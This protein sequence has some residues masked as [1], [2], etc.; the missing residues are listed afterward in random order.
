MLLRITSAAVTICLLS[1]PLLAQRIRESEVP[2]AVKNALVGRYPA[3]A[4]VS[5][6]K[7]KGNF[8]ANWGGQSK[9]DN[10]VLFTPSGEFVEM[11]AAIPVGSL[12]PAVTAYVRAHY[13]GVRITEAGKVT[14]AKGVVNYEAEVRGKDLRFDEK[15][16][17]VRI[18]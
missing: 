17:F 18:D 12:P 7:E 1:N 15:G 10:S 4:G 16:Q 14:D 6:E 5:W 13:P 9:E 11:V 3:A 8:E 2:S